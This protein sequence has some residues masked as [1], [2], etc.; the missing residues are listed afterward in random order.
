MPG[1]ENFDMSQMMQQMGGGAGG[2]PGMPGMGGGPEGTLIRPL[3]SR[4][5]LVMWL[6]M[7]VRIR[8]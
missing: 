5:G 8:L 6:N 1:M 4:N 2:M 7:E 3:Q